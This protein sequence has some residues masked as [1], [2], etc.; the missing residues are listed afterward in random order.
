[1]RGH[2][3]E[4]LMRGRESDVARVARFDGSLS[5]SV[6]PHAPDHAGASCEMNE[7]LSGV[8]V[9]VTGGSSG[10]GRAIALRLASEGANVAVTGRDATRLSA[11]VK[12]L[13]SAHG[14]HLAIQA[15]H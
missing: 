15:D 1:M 12:A 10:L 4:W 13:T 8:R 14:T 5:R 6:V 9:L 11:T 2:A 7:R 3:C